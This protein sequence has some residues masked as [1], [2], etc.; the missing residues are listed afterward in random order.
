MKK[1]LMIFAVLFLS[2]QIMVAQTTLK[3]KVKE[4][5]GKA[6]SG[7]VISG[8]DAQGKVTVTASSDAKGKFEINLPAGSDKIEVK[9]DGYQP[10]TLAVSKKKMKIE[11]LKQ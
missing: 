5:G 3:G 10:R 11:M 8:T 4:K 6:L 1:F 2:F 7:V 9:K